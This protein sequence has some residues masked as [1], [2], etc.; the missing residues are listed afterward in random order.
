MP[1]SANA[2]IRRRIFDLQS[3][4]TSSDS[5][6]A[7]CGRVSL[8]SMPRD[9]KG[10]ACSSS[11]WSPVEAATLLC[12]SFSLCPPPC[13]TLNI[14][15]DAVPLGNFSFSR[16]ITSFLRGTAKTT[17]NKHTPRLHRA[18]FQKFILNGPPS[19]VPPSPDGPS[20]PSLIRNSKAG[21]TPTNPQPRGI[22]PTAPATV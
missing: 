20:S 4:F 16:T 8:S 6:V 12:A 13:K 19:P 10:S 3:L 1:E 2:P 14:K 9:S 5:L 22:V 17:P 11:C 21:M 15:A 18:N 7:C